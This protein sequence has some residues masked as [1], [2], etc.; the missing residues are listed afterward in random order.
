MT[1][2]APA[3]AAG[4]ATLDVLDLQG[5]RVWS[6]PAAAH[7]TLRWD[8]RDAHGDPVAAGLYLVR[9]S[10]ASARRGVLSLR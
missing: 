1:F 9:L 3:D 7:A 5:R 4:G 2:A 10:T 6:A 8:G